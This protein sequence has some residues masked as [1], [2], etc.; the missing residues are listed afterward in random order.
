M[1]KA[2]TPR[3]PALEPLSKAAFARVVDLSRG[4]IKQLIASG[5]PVLPSGKIDRVAGQRWID[6]RLDPQRRT[7]A[8]P[9]TKLQAV[10]DLRA[11][12]ITQELL[13]L[14]MEIARKNGDLIDRKA[15]ERTMFERGR[16]ERDAWIGWISRTAPLLAATLGSDPAATFATLDKHVREHLAEF[17]ATPLEDFSDAG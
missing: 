13:L 12:K 17:A 15:A 3:M 1:R 10:A 5:L 4:R 11:D 6:T 7:A 9:K 14:K 16:Y 8:K 2:D